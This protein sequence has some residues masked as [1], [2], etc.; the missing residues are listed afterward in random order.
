MSL[1]H[2]FRGARFCHR[3]FFSGSLWM[4]LEAGDREAAGRA[5]KPVLLAKSAKNRSVAWRNPGGTSLKN[6]ASGSKNSGSGSKSSARQALAYHRRMGT[7]GAKLGTRSAAKP[8]SKPSSGCLARLALWTLGLVLTA[9]AAGVGGYLWLDATL[10]E[11]FTFKQYR[12][13]AKESSRVYA[14]GGEVVARF[15]DEIRTVI[16]GA[17]MGPNVRFAMICAEDSAFY[18]HPGLDFVGIARALWVDAST[19]R[20]AQGASTLTQQLAKTRFLSREKTVVRKLKELVLARKLEKNLSKDDILNLYLN[21][22]YFGHGRYGI[23]EAARFF[24]RR[25][26]AELDVAQAALLAGL[27]NS[28][29]KWSPLKHADR[30][31]TRRRYV[32]GQMHQK[33]YISAADL[34]KAQAQ[35]LPTIGGDAIAGAGPWYMDA[36]RRFVHAK[37]GRDQLASGGYRIEIA[38]DVALQQA[39]DAAVEQGLHNVDRLLSSGE[40][41]LRHPTDAAIAAGLA[42]LATQQPAKPTSGTVLQGIALS[43]D[44]VRKAWRFGLGNTEGF[45]GDADLG[46]Y[47]VWRSPRAGAAKGSEKPEP[48]QIERGD[49]VRV[50]VRELSED[51]IILSPEMGPQAALVALEPQTRLVRAL[52]GGDDFDLHPFDRSGALRQPGST[53]KTFAYGAAIEAGAANPDLVL[54]DEKRSFPTGGKPW[55]PRNFSGGYDGKSYSLRD[56]LAFSINSIAVEIASRV[57][58]EKIAAFAKRLGIASPLI[59]GLPLALGASSVTPF[60]ITNAYATIAAGGRYGEPVLVTRIVDRTGKDVYVAPRDKL[61]QVLGEGVAKQLTDMLGEVVR[62]GSAKGAQLAGRPLAGKTGTSNGG[63]DVWFVSFSAELCVGVWLGFDDR[64]PIPK[65]TGGSL[66]VP[67]ATQFYKEG[68]AAVPVVPLPRLPH[69]AA[70]PIAGLPAAIADSEA[71]ALDLHDDQL[72]PEVPIADKPPE[73]MPPKRRPLGQVDD[74]ALN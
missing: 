22:V 4:R 51:G 30:A 46:R 15:G 68:L 66:A 54:K 10:P 37:L 35:P 57:G 11:V 16:D 63:R 7:S 24:F 13:I 29:S 55:T 31:L 12:E 40:P 71:G 23:E 18:D 44:D 38:M 60:E 42:K 56:A 9:S 49:L 48:M 20:Y 52:V 41:L 28:P 1:W 53:F 74:E 26:A 50:S 39:A 33:G 14:A 43:H 73:P 47:K 65:G 3:P 72:G 64:K 6:S 58:P 34:A 70:G 45:L 36:V 67:I 61:A 25:S 69:V 2:G 19:G 27:V 59:A 17:Q 21:E 62:K 5:C 8:V 32:L